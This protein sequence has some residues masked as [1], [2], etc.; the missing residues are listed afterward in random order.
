MILL[1][2]AAAALTTYL[3]DW[4][5]TVIILAVVVFNTT[6][7]M[8]QQARAERAMAAL[9]QLVAPVARVVRDGVVA[10]LPADEVV[11]GDLVMVAAGD[12]LPADGTWWMP[13]ICRWTSRG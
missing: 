7:G 12:V 6:M 9:R 2:L 10:P 1:L 11:P 4:P 13:T 5:N 3:H 8:V